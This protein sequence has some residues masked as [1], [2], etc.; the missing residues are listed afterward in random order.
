MK[1]LA[2]LVSERECSL[3]NG[4]W[5]AADDSGQFAVTNPATG[6]TLALVPDMGAAETL[7]AV[8]AASDAFASWKR[9]PAQ[10]RAEIL[11]RWFALIKEHAD[12]LARLVT[13]EQGKPLREAQ[14]EVNYAAA[15]VEWF[16]EEAR[17]I[18]GSVIPSPFADRRYLATR[19]PV[20][21]VAAI[22]PWNFPLAMI[23]RK[24]A[25]ALA[26][27]CTV[28]L[29]P[30]EATPLSALALAE[31]AVRAGVPDGVLNV[32]TAAQGDK[33]GDALCS[34]ALVRKLSF[35][36]STVVGKLLL[37]KC[38]DTVKRVSL[39]LGGHAPFIV[40]DDAD[41]DAAVKGLMTAKFRNAG[42]TCVCANRV[43]V[44]E[45]VHDEFI[46]K[47]TAAMQG[48]RCGDGL[49]AATDIG[50]LIN[51]SAIAKVEQHVEDAV[52]KGAVLQSGGQVGDGQ[53]YQPTLLTGVSAD[54]LV[55]QEETFGP[56]VPV[57][58]FTSDDEV[59]AAAN[60]I[61]AGLAAYFYSRDIGRVWRVAEQLEYGMVGINTGIVS[62]EVV[63]FG[64][65]KESGLGREGSRQGIDEYLETRFISMAGLDA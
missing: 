8:D 41:V 49:D 14:G 10:Q 24:L 40:F 64:G 25:P 45:T 32:V 28:V 38:A 35:T 21:V 44:H 48:L 27:G 62:S 6:A 53:W 1:D 39:E 13:L 15:Y 56:V 4:S 42:Q 31:L 12:E 29:K 22:T 20:G 16:A 2:G 34:S 61:S 9:V 18:D 58:R 60:N 30:A 59:L 33:V 46:T 23:T 47:L 37:K 36:G 43:Y 55:A 19:Q 5:V 7:R 50:P 54:M 63:P 11:R 26:A 52:A 3:I 17:R 57:I 51:P 65:V